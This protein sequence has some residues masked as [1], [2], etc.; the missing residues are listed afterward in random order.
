MDTARHSTSTRIGELYPFLR[1]GLYYEQVKRYQA[2]FVADRVQIHFYEDFTRDSRAVLRTI[3]RFLS[4]DP[5][6][7]PDFSTRHMEAAVPRFFFLKSAL[8]RLGIWDAVRGRLPGGARSRLRGV[9]FQ[10][11]N[12]I[13]LEPADQASLA[14][15][16]RDDVEKLSNLLNRDLSPWLDGGD[17]R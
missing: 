11:R 7:A 2:A 1:F 9:A 17:R 3:F 14:E 12:A 16:Y 15:Y 4:V 13:M 5:D 6:F 8:K 10:P